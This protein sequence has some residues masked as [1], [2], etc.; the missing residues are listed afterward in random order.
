MSGAATAISSMVYRVHQFARSHA[1]YPGTTSALTYQIQLASPYLSIAA[2]VNRQENNADA[3]Y[4]Q[5]PASS[6]T[7]MEIAQ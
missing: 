6:I 3:A 1:D 5:F 7:V 4:I 2:H